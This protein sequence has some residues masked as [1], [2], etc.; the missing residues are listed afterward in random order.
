[1]L[2]VN[3]KIHYSPEK[4]IIA[5]DT[6]DYDLL[7]ELRNLKHSLHENADIEMQHLYPE[8]YIFLNAIYGLAWCNFLEGLDGESEYFNEGHGEIQRVFDKIDSDTGRSSFDEDLPLPY[9]AFYT[10]WSTYLLGRKLYLEPPSKRK[11]TEV[12][13]FRQKCENIASSINEKIYPESYHGSAWPADVVLCMATLALH[14]KLF[15]PHYSD[16]IKNWLMKVKSTL[17]SHG[18]I[19][20]SSNP[21]SGMP[22]ENARGSS[23]SLMLVF[24]HSIDKEFALKQFS[25]YKTNFVDEKF[26]L[27]GIREYAKDDFGASDVDSGP[28]ILKFGSAATIVGMYTLSL[29]GEYDMSLGI[30]N[31]IEAFGFTLNKGDQKTYLFGL[32]PMVDAFIAWAHSAESRQSTSLPSFLTFHTYS[33]FI[34]VVLIAFLWILLKTGV[35]NSRRSDS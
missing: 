15:E 31:T 4:R 23:Q 13:F 30:R 34:F 28:V 24:L 2:I 17:D 12:D 3:V 33:G 18:L 1:M 35:P 8:G 6:I 32:L 11:K 26:G 16:A 10:G 29:Y 21:L 5:R 14:D 27:T 22:I 7:K 25:I 9:G 20:H 19:S